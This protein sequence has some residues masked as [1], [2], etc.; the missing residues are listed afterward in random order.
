MFK[1]TIIALAVSFL[2]GCADAG[3]GLGARDYTR[4][5]AR[6]TQD[7]QYG[8]VRDVRHVQIRG[9]TQASSLVGTGVGA[10]LGGVLGNQVGGGQGR[11]VATVLGA[12]AGGVAGNAVEG[13][14]NTQRGLEITVQLD[15]GRTI[16]VTEAE[17]QQD[18][19]RGDRVQVVSDS[20]GVTRIER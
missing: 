7:V 10:I 11:T 17:D 18:I 4:Y 2:G 16:G 15:S 12:V 1:F 14:A 6:Q 19:Q 5:Q 8:V 9:S 20:Q 3:G 13:R